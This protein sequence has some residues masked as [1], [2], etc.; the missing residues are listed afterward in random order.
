MLGGIGAG[1]EGD[2]RGWDG[3]MASLTRWTWVWVN[4]GS[5]WWIRRPG[6]LRFMGSQRVGHD[7]VTELNWTDCYLL[8]FSGGSDGKESACSSGDLDSIPG[9]GRCPGGGNGNPRQYSCLENSKDRGAIG[10]QRARYN[11]ATNSFLPFCLP[12]P[13]FSSPKTVQPSFLDL[14]ALFLCMYDDLGWPRSLLT[15]IIFPCWKYG[16]RITFPSIPITLH[17]PRFY[18]HTHTNT[19][20]HFWILQHI[21][22]NTSEGKL[23]ELS[24]WGGFQNINMKR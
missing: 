14:L 6:V 19:H 5:W 8:G 24:S 16:N 4:S 17:Y 10:S 1:V 15:L 11:W 13:T 7:W 2:D 20:T 18:K 21:Y 22:V 23:T 12:L 9:S 3:W